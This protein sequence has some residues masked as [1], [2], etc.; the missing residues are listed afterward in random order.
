MKVKWQA[1]E[2]TQKRKETE[3][4]IKLVRKK[5]KKGKNW[6]LCCSPHVV[7]A[8]AA[9]PNPNLPARVELAVCERS[10]FG[11]DIVLQPKF[12]TWKLADGKEYNKQ[13]SHAH[14]T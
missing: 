7:I 11:F 14:A 5:K 8:P 2:R 1:G 9:R 6:S 12:T 3:K 13:F 10:K 4:K